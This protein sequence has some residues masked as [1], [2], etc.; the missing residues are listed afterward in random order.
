MRI[1]P[2][3]TNENSTPVSVVTHIVKSFS[4]YSLIDT[5]LEYLFPYLWVL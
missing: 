3:E 2:I 4:V 1:K 5:L